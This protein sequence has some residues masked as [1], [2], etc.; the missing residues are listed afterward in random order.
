MKTY[1]AIFL[2]SSQLFSNDDYVQ[3]ATASDETAANLILWKPKHGFR[4]PGR[5]KLDYVTLLMQDTSLTN[6]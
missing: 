4:R 5:P 6:E 1:M 2:R 3:P